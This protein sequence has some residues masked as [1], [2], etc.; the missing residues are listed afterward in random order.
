MRRCAEVSGMGAGARLY[1]ALAR[2]ERGLPVLIDR[3]HRV[4]L[5]RGCL[6]CE[7][8]EEGTRGERIK[9]AACLAN[10]KRTFVPPKRFG[11]GI[12]MGPKKEETPEEPPSLVGARVRLRPGAAAPEGGWG[13]AGPPSEAEASSLLFNGKRTRSATASCCASV[14]DA[15][16]SVRRTRPFVSHP[17]DRVN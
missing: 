17:V 4:R 2:L 15:C 7:A 16:G 9:P 8:S 1:L 10:P 12:G 14:A 6:V 3:R 5:V 11:T 13:T